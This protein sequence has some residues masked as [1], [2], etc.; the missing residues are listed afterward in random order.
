MEKSINI[1]KNSNI[2]I[3]NIEHA[4]FYIDQAIKTQSGRWIHV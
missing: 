1:L 3:F 2:I 4:Q